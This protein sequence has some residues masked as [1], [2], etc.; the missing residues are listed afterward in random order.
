M[1]LARRP[2]RWSRPVIALHWTAAA[3]ILV[4]L[5]IGWA[6]VHGE[7][8]A[9]R[10]F[11]L[12]Q[13]HKS[14]G[15]MA[16]VLTALRLV[17]RLAAAPAPLPSPPWER[18]LAALV[19]GALYLLTIVALLSG[20]LAVSSSPLPIPSRFFDL[21]V[22]PNI[23]GPDAAVYAVAARVHA[24]AVW[25]IAGLVALHTAGALKHAFVNRDGALARMLPGR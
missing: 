17:A 5:V 4:L 3:I 24:V 1:S 18:R 6:M 22:V 12:F 8:D 23:A 20:W 9:A 15:F 25:A 16:L 2:E 19:Q 21:F 13:L 14:L 7:L 11:D 10:T